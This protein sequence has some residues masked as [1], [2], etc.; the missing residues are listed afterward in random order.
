MAIA[1][2]NPAQLSR[3]TMARQLLLERAP[4]EPAAAISRLCALQAQ[5][6]R[7]PYLALWS[8]IAGFA[9]GQLT[10]ALDDR[11]VLRVTLMRGTLH[12]VTAADYPQL[13]APLQPVLAESF[14]GRGDRAA[15]IELDRVLPAAR[16]AYADGPMTFEELRTRLAPD[17]PGLD[18]RMLG[19]A[20]RMNLPLAIEPTADQWGYPRAPEFGLTD[21]FGTETDPAGL[22]LRYLAAFGPA[23]AAD[24]QSFLGLPRLG[25]IMDRL[26]SRL[27]TFADQRGRT[28]YDL[29]DA[30]RPDQD[31][32]A[33]PRFVPEFDNL[34]LGYSD[35]TRFLAEEFKGQ[36]TTRNLRVRPTFLHGGVIRGT[37]AMTRKAKAATLT[38]TPFEPLS[39]RAV[40]ELEA[41][42]EA[43]LRFAEPDA[44]AHRVELA[45]P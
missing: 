7:P 45:G 25:A 34:V 26:A 11:S 29:P 14:T 43:L 13:R 32:S 42:G 12:L 24:A 8:R 17:F 4:L 44:P 19:Y 18:V 22:L 16:S 36:V 23:T 2:L 5:E 1:T 40:T 10:A 33:P 21:E 38:M 39:R 31:T 6:P 37:W 20:V 27:V 9:A 35:R 15:G 30:P 41:E 28:L 3:A